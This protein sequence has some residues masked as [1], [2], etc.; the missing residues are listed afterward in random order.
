MSYPSRC[1]HP[2]KLTGCQQNY[3]YLLTVRY[4]LRERS[5][6]T[7]S[8]PG[9]STDS[10]YTVTGSK[11]QNWITPCLLPS[12]PLSELV[13]DKCIVNINESVGTKR[14]TLREHISNYIIYCISSSSG[15]LILIMEALSKQFHCIHNPLQREQSNLFNIY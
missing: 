6:A 11:E 3:R 15:L 4:F 7:L 14:N 12:F 13:V 1:E 5:L 10:V 8:S 2:S 9:M